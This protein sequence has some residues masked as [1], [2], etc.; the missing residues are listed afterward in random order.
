MA[1]SSILE[2][3]EHLQKKQ[4]QQQAARERYSDLV[5]SVVSQKAEYVK[6]A[7]LEGEVQHT[8]E[9][10][11]QRTF[12]R[13][14]DDYSTTNSIYIP[15]MEMSK[16]E[17]TFWKKVVTQA[18]KAGCDIE[19]FLKAQFDYF[20][21]TFKKAPEYKHLLTDAAILRAKEYKLSAQRIIGSVEDKQTLAELFGACN[22]QLLQIQKAQKMSREQ[23]YE[24][25]VIPGH[26]YFP[27]AFLQ[28][29]PV[30]RK[31]KEK[32]G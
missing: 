24:K 21:R 1:D 29:D 20:H 13:L 32:H 27:Q 12:H 11:A 17:I 2:V 25:L 16:K 7:V 30:Y 14:R 28:A 6:V 18:K 4:R 22:K 19:H 9:V 31:I 23:V 8:E 10:L 15:K 5:N 26:V 3:L